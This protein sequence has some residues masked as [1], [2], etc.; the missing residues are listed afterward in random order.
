MVSSF[1]SRSS[2]Y[3]SVCKPQPELEILRDFESFK[4]DLAFGSTWTG[5]DSEKILTP[6]VEA[7]SHR[8]VFPS[9]LDCV[10]YQ[11]T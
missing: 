11:S 2:P 1:S 6:A 3:A 7:L 4:D 9:S 8:Y 10:H 5:S